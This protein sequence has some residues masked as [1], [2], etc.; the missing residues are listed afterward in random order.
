MS[1]AQQYEFHAKRPSVYLDQ[2]VWVRLAKAAAGEPRETGDDLVLKAVESAR[3]AGVAFPL[4]ST[5]YI[6]TSRVRSHRQRTDLAN[7]MGSISHFRTLRPRRELLR[8]QL[9]T[10]MQEI[11]G[12]PTF[13]PEYL[14]PLGVGVYWTFRSEHRRLTLHGPQEVLDAVDGSLTPDVL[15]RASQWAELQFLAGPRDED[16]T[17]LREQYGYR[18]ET[19][20]EMG[21]SRLNWEEAYVGLLRDDPIT[22]A[23]LRVRVQAR[24]VAHE[25]LDLLIGLFKEYGLS[26][27]RLTGGPSAEPG[28]GRPRMTAFFDAMPSVRAAV[29]MKV[30]LFRNRSNTWKVNDL[31]DIDAASLAI[32]YCHVI[33]ADKAK[34]AALL[35][36]GS[37]KHNGTRLVRRLLDL[38]DIL[39]PM[40]VAARALGGD[41]IGWD[42]CNPGVAFE[43][44]S[45]EAVF[46]RKGSIR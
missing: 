3:D 23:E 33:V 34:V 26:L 24:E 20:E 14:E 41:P 29:D 8:H 10:V 5:H 1:Y 31:Y 46:K 17:K 4:S 21:A 44:L 42:W 36:T 6:E 27:D 11:L 35:R 28:S 39:P 16:I 2:W 18:P 19:T 25:H 30:E 32:P 45:P 12:R 15:C 13:S 7:V 40:E 9:L 37:D 43:P 22:R 38:V